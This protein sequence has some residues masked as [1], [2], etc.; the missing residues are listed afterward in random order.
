MVSQQ[1]HTNIFWF[2]RKDE[3]FEIEV[4]GF[5]AAFLCVGA[6]FP[7]VIRLYKRKSAG[8]ISLVWNITYLLS[9]IAWIIYGLSISS[10]PIII[11]NIL[12]GI[13]AILILIARIIYRKCLE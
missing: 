4:I 6:F 8:D 7:Q 3:M 10:F 2:L 5:I 11:A 9:V 13:L 12:I 1:R